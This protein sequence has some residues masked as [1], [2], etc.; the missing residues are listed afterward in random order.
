MRLVLYH[1][2]GL[3]GCERWAFPANAADDTS[4]ASVHHASVYAVLSDCVPL[5]YMLHP[6]AFSLAFSLLISAAASF[7]RLSAHTSMRSS[8]VGLWVCL[9]PVHMAQFHMLHLSVIGSC[10]FAL[11]R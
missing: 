10:S 1:R 8:S 3:A 2:M 6:L 7:I 4:L 11:G 9:C 5:A